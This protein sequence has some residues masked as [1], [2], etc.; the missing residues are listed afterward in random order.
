VVVL[1]QDSSADPF[2]I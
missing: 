2:S 1:I